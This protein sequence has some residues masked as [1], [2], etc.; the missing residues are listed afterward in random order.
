MDPAT[1]SLDLFLAENHGVLSRAEARRFGLSPDQI[2]HRLR[3]GRW[4]AAGPNAYRLASAPDTWHARARAAAL[5]CRGLVSHTSAL[6]V[7]GVDGWTD[8]RRLH[9]TVA[10]GRRLERH[11]VTIFRSTAI[12]RAGHR[13]VDGIPVTG[14]ERSVLD[15]AAIAPERIDQT[16]DAVLRQRLATLT[17]LVDE[18]ERAGIRGRAGAGRLRRLLAERDPSRRTPDSRFN[19]LVAELLVDA[20]LPTPVFEHE[21]RVGRRIARVDLAYPQ[22]GLAIELDSARW[23]QDRRSFTADPRRKNRLLLAGWSVLSFTW[24][25]Y[26]ESPEYLVGAVSAALATRGPGMAS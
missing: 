16:I 6:R 8:H 7:W 13:I 26:A 20:G 22:M 9:V 17:S 2:T 11:G 12:E 14:V 19:R 21:V 15:A 3:T 25:D 18:V 24:A 23:H 4:L 10:A 5:S 1:P